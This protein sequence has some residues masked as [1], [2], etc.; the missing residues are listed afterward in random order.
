MTF[1]LLVCDLD[2]TLY[3]WGQY[4][5]QSFYSMINEIEKITNLDRELIL[6][7]FKRVHQYH[8]DSEH[9]FALL[10]TDFVKKL[11]KNLS[12]KEILEKYDPAFHAF[13]SMRIKT[14]V[15]YNGVSDTLNT[16]SSHGVKIV[17]HTE[18]KLHGV[19]DRLRKLN[20]VNYFEA[21]YCRERSETLH[22]TNLSFEEWAGDFPLNKV[23]ELSK[24][25]RKPEVSVLLEICKKSYIDT[26]NTAYIGDSIAR[27]I[28][29]AKNAGV[30]SIF[31]EY[32]T[33]HFNDYYE[34]LVRITH[35]TKED[36]EK[37][38]RLKNEAK[39]IKPDFIASHTI[40]EILIPFNLN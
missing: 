30:F 11:D 23:V 1:K 34:K 33:K 15:E 36:V 6:D 21:I 22:P 35:W 32:G 37:E 39:D 20:L 10:E 40:R 9:P 29:M 3:D 12:K 27:D 5:S 28:V 2:N 18:S 19:I 31:A 4:F 13:N 24:H 26:K 14:L 25:Q 7:D 38:I 17:A 8:H 16:L